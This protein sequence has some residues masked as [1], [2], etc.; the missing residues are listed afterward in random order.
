MYLNAARMHTQQKHF[1]L[2]LTKDFPGRRT[3]SIFRHLYWDSRFYSGSHKE[4]SCSFFWL[5]TPQN[6]NNNNNNNNSN[7]NNKKNNRE[8]RPKT[9]TTQPHTQKNRRACLETKN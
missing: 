8:N 1:F 7:T 4:A 6:N 2:V 5:S 3:A 9:K